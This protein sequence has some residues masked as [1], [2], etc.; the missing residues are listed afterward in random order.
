MTEGLEARVARSAARS[1]R[2]PAASTRASSPRSPHRALGDRALAVT[3]VS[4]SVAAGELD[5]ARRVA[6]HIGIAHEI[7]S[8]N[9]LAR[10]RLPRQRPRPLLLLQVR[11]LRRARSARYPRRARAAL[12]RQRRRPGRLAPRA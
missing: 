7:V 9:E 8:T 12:R 11:A 2:S 6:A 10:A 5:G 3:A 1:S 4:P